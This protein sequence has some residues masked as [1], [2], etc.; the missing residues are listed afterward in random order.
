VTVNRPLEQKLM[1]R[2]CQRP[3]LTS[4]VFILI[5]AHIQ[6]IKTAAFLID[7][8]IFRVC[9]VNRCPVVSCMLHE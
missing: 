3:S 5:R 9:I 4:D 8:N 1:S 6:V 2:V 7:I